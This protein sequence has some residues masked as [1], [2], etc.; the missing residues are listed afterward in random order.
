MRAEIVTVGTELLLGQIVDTNSAWLAERLA[1]LGVDVNWQTKVGDN[2]GRMCEAFRLAL[3]RADAVVVTGGLGPTQDDVTREAIAEVSGRP[4]RRD[5]EIAALLER[6]FAGIGREMAASNLRQ[7]DVPEGAST[8]PMRVGTAPGLVVPAGD[9]VVYALPGVPHEMKEMWDRGVVPDL[10][11]RMG[12]TAT[13]RSRMLKCWGVSESRLGELLA[14]RFEALGATGTATIAF[15]ASEGVV[16]VRITVKGTDDAAIDDLLAA[17]ERIIRDILGEV[18]FGVDDDTIESVVIDGLRERGMTLATAESMTGGTVGAWLTRVP[19]AS[20][21]YRGG[22]VTYAA[23]VKTSVLGVAAETI[24]RHGVV[25]EE[26]ATAMSAGA[27][28]VFG[29]DVGLAITGSAGP[30]AQ[31]SSI[32]EACLAI[33]LAGDTTVASVRF[34]GDRERVRAFAA[35]TILDLLRRRLPE[36]GPGDGLHDGRPG[37]LQDG[38]GAERDFGE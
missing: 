9:G 15:L 8:I 12:E 4:L 27:R 28:R 26:T 29:A 14:Q 18:V 3:G 34:P 37:G 10:L 22:A 38:G 21:V 20:E 7:A 23:D 5:P 32:G 2:H 19:G 31:G 17:E 30:T 6:I 16:R 35:A 36:R 13:I 1:G 11:A 24:E 33:D 25:S